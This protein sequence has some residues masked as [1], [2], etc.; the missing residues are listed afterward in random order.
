MG[1][2]DAAAGVMAFAFINRSILIVEYNTSEM[3]KLKAFL[4]PRCF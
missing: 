1:L 3:I 2:P 4:G